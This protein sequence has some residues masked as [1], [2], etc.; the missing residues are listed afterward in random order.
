VRKK[1][2]LLVD[3]DRK[4]LLALERVLAF[5]VQVDSCADFVRAR[6]RLIA[7]PPNLLVTHSRLGEYNGLQ[8]AHLATALTLPTRVVVYGQADDLALARETQIAGAFY[9]PS[10]QI[11]AALPAYLDAELPP[12]DRRDAAR[13][14]R[15]HQVRGGRRA[16]DPDARL[17]S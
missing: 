4:R 2:L 10:Q 6:A 7:R 15:R 1:D 3:L 14:D 9:V 16:T 5:R 17:A 11:V 12:Q 8:L 13:P